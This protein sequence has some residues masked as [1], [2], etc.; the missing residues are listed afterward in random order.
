MQTRSVIRY[1]SRWVYPAKT[2][3]P[4]LAKPLHKS[5]GC[6][7]DHTQPTQIEECLRYR[8]GR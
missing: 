8:V 4:Q 6:R 1:Q 7:I 3:L 5:D 2:K